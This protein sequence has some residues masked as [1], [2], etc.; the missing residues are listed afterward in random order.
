MEN[1]PFLKEIEKILLLKRTLKFSIAYKWNGSS[2]LR[3]GSSN[4]KNY[5]FS[6]TSSY[7]LS[8]KA[9]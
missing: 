9:C 4:L 7:R 6:A 1:Q 3:A 5:F 8:D 2:L